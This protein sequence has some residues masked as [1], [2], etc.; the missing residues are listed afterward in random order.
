MLQSLFCSI[1]EGFGSKNILSN[2]QKTIRAA[3]WLMVS[4]VPSNALVVPLGTS[5]YCS[6]TV[7]ATM[8]R[9]KTIQNKPHT[10][11]FVVSLDFFFLHSASKKTFKTPSLFRDLQHLHLTG[12]CQIPKRF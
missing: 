12:I 2:L 4:L 9:A 3:I 1:M 10:V 7:V 8:H 6:N 5:N 11:R